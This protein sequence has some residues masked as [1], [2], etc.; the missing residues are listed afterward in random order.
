MIIM[1]NDAYYDGEWKNGS[2]EGQGKYKW[3]DGSIY[4]GEWIG[5]KA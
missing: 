5:N 3:A 2:R 1:E 4:I